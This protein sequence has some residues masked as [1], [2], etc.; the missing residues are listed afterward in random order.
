LASRASA[1]KIIIKE[2]KAPNQHFG[3]FLDGKNIRQYQE[4][5]RMENII[6]KSS[7]KTTML[8]YRNLAQNILD[9]FL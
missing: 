6:H 4:K 5:R 3:L 9:I 1:R 8:W 2:K 7:W